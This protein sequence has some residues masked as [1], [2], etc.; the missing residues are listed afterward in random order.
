MCLRE[1]AE[2]QIIMGTEILLAHGIIK[3]LV[4]VVMS[5]TR[6]IIMRL[7]GLELMLRG[8]L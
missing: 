2:R 3:I 1:L 6:V 4:M 8:R 5:N 7:K